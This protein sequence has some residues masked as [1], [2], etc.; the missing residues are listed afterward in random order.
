MSRPVNRQSRSVGNLG[1][2]LKHAALVELASLLAATT[3]RVDWVDTH[4]YLLHA[5][6]ADRER[7]AHEVEAR[8]RRWPAYERYLEIQRAS[9][10]ETSRVRCSSGLVMGVLGDRRGT[11][12]MGEANGATREELRA[13]VSLAGWTDVSVAEDGVGALRAVA[14]ADVDATG[15]GRGVLVHVDPFALTAEEWAPLASGLDAVC[16]GARSA[17]LVVYR[18]TRGG[19][20]PWPAA[21]AGTVGPVAEVRGGPHLVAAYASASIV[22]DVRDA[23]VSLGWSRG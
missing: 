20:T 13:Q 16:G 23:C 5:P 18:Y 6:P 7:W 11:T 4:T 9:L 8:L 21:P 14:D 10:A 22:S 2:V 3:S 17:V 15:S 1:D 12:A 19:R